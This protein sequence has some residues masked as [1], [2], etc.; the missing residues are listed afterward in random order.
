[1][2]ERRRKE[3]ERREPGEEIDDEERIPCVR[4]RYACPSGRRGDRALCRSRFP[5]ASRRIGPIPRPGAPIGRAFRW[6]AQLPG[7]AAVLSPDTRRG[8][9]AR[10]SY[11]AREQ[12]ARRE[13][14][15]ARRPG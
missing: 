15:A 3:R 11:R 12:L 2:A 9:A 5:A 1:P 7:G 4:F 6:H 8:G 14:T 10:E 13:A